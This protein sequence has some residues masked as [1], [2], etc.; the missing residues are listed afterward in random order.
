MMSTIIPVIYPR[1]MRSPQINATINFG[2]SSDPSVARGRERPRTTLFASTTWP[3]PR[4]RNPRG[5][6]MARQ[7]LTL[8]T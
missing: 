2:G 4:R 1:S 7:P 5:V 8:Y 6:S 3:G